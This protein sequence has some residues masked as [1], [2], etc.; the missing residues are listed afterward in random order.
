MRI[1][2]LG[3]DMTIDEADRL[4]DWLKMDSGKKFWQAIQAMRS[5]CYDQ[6][7]GKSINDPVE[8]VLMTQRQKAILATLDE[9]IKIP[10]DVDEGI[11]FEKD[12]KKDVDNV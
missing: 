7:I 12:S 4:N 8:E 9:I 5:D 3:I 2:L 11:T 6:F 10:V 1:N